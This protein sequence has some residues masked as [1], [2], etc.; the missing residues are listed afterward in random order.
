[1][2]NNKE[3]AL[4]PI[5]NRPVSYLL[6]K[7]IAD[8]AGINLNLPDRKKL[9]DLQNGS[10]LSYIDEWVNGLT[11]NSC[12]I[13]S[14]DNWIYGGLV[15][16]RKH[17]SS[18]ETLK[19]RVSD[20]IKIN[21]I[22]KYGFS[23]IMRI[24]DYNN[25]DEEKDYWKKY[26]EKIHKWSK[27]MHMVG[28]G[29]KEEYKTHDELIEDWYQST[30][31]IPVEI[32]TNYKSH[33]DTNFS[34]NML[35]QDSLHEKSFN[36]LIFSS[37]DSSK[38]GLNVIESEYLRNEI[39]KHRFESIAKVISGTDEIPLV[40]LTKAQLDITKLKPSISVNFTSI[41]GAN[42]I[43]R[44]E[45][46]TIRSSVLNQL[47]VLNI[48]I[49]DPEKSD[50][51]LIVHL[52][53]STQ[54]DHIFNLQPENTEKSVNNIINI[55]KKS[56]KSF[57]IADLAYANGADPKLIN[58]LI[59]SEINWENC[60]GFSA[61]NTCSNTVGSAL[62]I[63]INRWIA[64]KNNVFNKTAFKKCLLTRFLDDFAYQAEIRSLNKGEKEI[65]DMMK[66]HV[67]KFSTLLRLDNIST[68]CRLPWNRSFEIEIEFVN[69]I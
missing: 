13:L 66:K 35:W 64:E 21:K 58:S 60:Y 9:G 36:Y 57:I 67:Q 63:G 18:F 52:S 42:Q 5:D 37:D 2:Q 10:D 16:S 28:R 46:N 69:V 61:W 31:G 56:E 23:S 43:A 30:K 1:M 62:A 51:S 25:T 24:P 27:L 22:T 15:Q 59:N 17:S 8:F 49:T 44:Y 7:Q 48:E 20:L 53:D 12:L 19:K 33:R 3:I 29:I 38:Y 54:G 40:L 50:I 41:D 39:K 6:P 4:L 45:S 68:R 55:L 11:S 47:E 26:G 65:N 34:I 32:L 14:L